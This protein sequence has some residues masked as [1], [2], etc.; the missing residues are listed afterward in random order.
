MRKSVLPNS[1]LNGAARKGFQG[2]PSP[3]HPVSCGK[4]ITVE[5]SECRVRLAKQHL[6]HMTAFAV[7]AMVSFERGID[8]SISNLNDGLELGVS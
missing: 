2:V 8:C 1:L 6:Q 7:V 4:C 3:P 5:G